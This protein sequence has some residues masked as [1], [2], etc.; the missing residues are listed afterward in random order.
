[1]PEAA[2][3]KGRRS[4][5][6]LIVWL[7]GW[8]AIA[9]AK[10]PAFTVAVVVPLIAPDVAVIMDVPAAIALAIPAALIAAVAGVAEFHVA[11]AVRFCMLPLL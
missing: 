1:M 3:E 10:A 4:G 11:V 9:G 6:A 7:T 5:P 8:V 2:T